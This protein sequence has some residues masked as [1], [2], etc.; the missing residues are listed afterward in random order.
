MVQEWG[1]GGGQK[2]ED[3]RNNES[4]CPGD[5]RADVY[6]EGVTTEMPLAVNGAEC[7][8]GSGQGVCSPDFI[9]CVN[10]DFSVRLLLSP[11]GQMPLCLMSEDRKMS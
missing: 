6:K 9:T 10:I 8:H 3:D 5:T 2:R 4:E 1:V 11:T 7:W